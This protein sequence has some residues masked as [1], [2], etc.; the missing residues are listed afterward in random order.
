M[1]LNAI[2]GKNSVLN[3]SKNTSSPGKAKTQA[4]LPERK[5]VDEQSAGKLEALQRSNFLGITVAKHS[6]ESKELNIMAYKFLVLAG[7]DPQTALDMLAFENPND[8][9]DTAMDSL[10]AL[11]PTG[12][13]HRTESGRMISNALEESNGD[14][15]KA[16]NSLSDLEPTTV[17]LNAREALSSMVIVN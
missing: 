2:S 14:P 12:V 13:S 15:K 6:V 11:L 17:V 4:S 16:L 10:K 9:V 5:A 7:G 8:A 3:Q 1:T